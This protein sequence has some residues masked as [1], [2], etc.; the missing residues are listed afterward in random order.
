ME[1]WKDIEGFPGY[2]VSSLGR[3]KGVFDKILKPQKHRNGYC[4]ISLFKETHRRNLTI[5]RLV[6]QAFLPPTIDRFEIDHI[7]RD[8]KDNRVENLRWATRSENNI[9]KSYTSESGIR[10]IRQRTDSSWEVKIHRG[11]RLIH[12]KYCYSVEE[13]VKARDE[14]LTSLNQ[15]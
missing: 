14:F 12:Y 3:V 9:N 2:Q 5:H 6:G 8:K 4:M 1:L 13:A 10:N 11:G 15:S 7:N